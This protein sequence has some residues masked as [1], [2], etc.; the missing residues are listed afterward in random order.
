MALFTASIFIFIL[1]VLWQLAATNTFFKYLEK[2]HP[3]EFARLGYPKWRIEFGNVILRNAI[4]YIHTKSFEPLGDEELM[5][6]YRSI[7]NA[8]RLAYA[9]AALALG[10]S[11]YEAIKPSL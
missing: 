10:S 4:K 8:E 2:E 7:R 3:N 6:H 9:M 11:I 5:N 1:A